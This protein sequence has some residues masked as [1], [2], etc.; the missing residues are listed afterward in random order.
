M[1]V[2]DGRIPSAAELVEYANGQKELD[3]ALGVQTESVDEVIKPRA[4]PREVKH[5]PE[6][7]NLA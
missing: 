2:F 4:A 6:T 7:L 1:A 5:L 3:E